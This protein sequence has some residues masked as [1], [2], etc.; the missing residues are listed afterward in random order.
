[1][2]TGLLA[3]NITKNA[4]PKAGAV[5]VATTVQLIIASQGTPITNRAT[6]KMT[7]KIAPRRQ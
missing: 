6:K 3:G 2:V 4:G 1:M 5:V 7:P